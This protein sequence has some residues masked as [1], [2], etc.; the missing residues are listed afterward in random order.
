MLLHSSH[1]TTE[2]YPARQRTHAW[3]EMLSKFSLQVTDV[4]DEDEMYGTVSSA[5]SPHGILFARI[6]AGPQGLIYREDDN[7]SGAICLALH[8]EGRAM[9]M[10]PAEQTW[11]AS[12]DIVYGPAGA[13]GGV[14]MQSNF[15]QLFVKIPRQALRS[16]LAV[17]MSLKV[18]YLSGQSGIGH[19]FAGMLGSIADTL[20][21]LTPDQIRPIEIALLEFLVSS[22]ADDETAQGM[23]AGTSTQTTN[24]HRISQ[25]IES[26][27]GDPDLTIAKAAD[28]S[29][30]SARYLQKLFEAVGE[31]FSHYVR[32]RRLER[33][34][35]DL[36]NPL[37][38]HLSISDIC[39]RWSFN[40]AAHFS[41]AFREQYN[42]SPRAYRRDIGASIAKSMLQNIS[43]G[44]P[45]VPREAENRLERPE[46]PAAEEQQLRAPPADDVAAAEPE[47]GARLI[48][49]EGKFRHFYLPANDKTVHWGYF[50]RS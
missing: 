7:R 12:G 20:D 38:S 41:R 39:F 35:S 48:S 26:R 22:L 5:V 46:A 37:Y 40:D 9:L 50:S 13:S 49:V 19:V 18:G 6:S 10:E 32:A 2:S 28:E 16:R 14:S 1:F 25:L 29:G 23:I 44:W 17:P 33:C 36:I 4:V 42:T 21:K 31:S 30:V 24:L 34:R 27:L 15:R 8:M 3:R 47:A 43:R 45:E 11:L